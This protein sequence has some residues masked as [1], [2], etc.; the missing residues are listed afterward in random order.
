[1]TKQVADEEITRPNNS[2]K[3]TEAETGIQGRILKDCLSI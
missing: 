2:I 1:M 3:E